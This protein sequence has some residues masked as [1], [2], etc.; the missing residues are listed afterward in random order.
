MNVK[1]NKGFTLIELAIVIVIVA[2]LAAVAVPRFSNVTR[3]AQGSVVQ[4][5]LAQVTSAASIYTAEQQRTPTAFTDYVSGGA[6]ANNHTLTLQNVGNASAPACAIAANT[7]TCGGG[8]A[9]TRFPDLGATA[10]INFNQGPGTFNLNCAAPAGAA[11][12][13]QAWQP[14]SCRYAA[15]AAAP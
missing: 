9:G 1:A 8:A 14:A 5:M 10:T 11:P 13:G 2:I 15:A 3:T 6:L 12:A 4:D 7:I